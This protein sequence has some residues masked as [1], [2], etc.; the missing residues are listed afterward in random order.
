MNLDTLTQE[1][2][3]DLTLPLYPGNS[4]TEL[5]V[6]VCACACMRACVCVCVR[7]RDLESS[8]SAG[9]IHL[10]LT[11]TGTTAQEVEGDTATSNRSLWQSRS[12]ADM[13]DRYVSKHVC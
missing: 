8:F 6:C 13:V 10:L 12:T 2:T 3:H 7:Q 11:I 5:C 9:T 1:Q 4:G